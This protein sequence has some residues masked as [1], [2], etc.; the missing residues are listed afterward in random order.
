MRVV[1][2]RRDTLARA[3]QR[4]FACAP[5]GL[6]RPKGKKKVLIIFDDFTQQELKEIFIECVIL[7]YE[8]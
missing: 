3:V 2:A 1:G 5:S 4:G 8:T 7:N 6:E